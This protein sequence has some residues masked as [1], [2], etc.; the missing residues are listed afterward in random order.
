MGLADGEPMP[1]TP[2]TARPG[3][4]GMAQ[5]Q[6]AGAFEDRNLRTM[7]LPSLEEALQAAGSAAAADLD[8]DAARAF[9][10]AFVEHCK[11]LLDVVRHLR[12]DQV[13]LAPPAREGAC[14]QAD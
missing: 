8:K 5:S 2:R 1:P 14:T 4:P 13:R 12:F 6:Q 9:W 3:M 11:S 10:A 7:A